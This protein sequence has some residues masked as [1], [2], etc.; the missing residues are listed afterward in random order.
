V[1]FTNL[2]DGIETQSQVWR[3]KVRIIRH[4]RQMEFEN[5][6][7]LIHEMVSNASPEPFYWVGGEKHIMQKVSGSKFVMASAETSVGVQVVD[8]FLWLAKKGFAGESLPHDCFK[9]MQYV[10]RRGNIHDFSFRGVSQAMHEQYGDVLSK[11]LTPQEVVKAKDIQA[12]FEE[13]RQKA[14]A[15]YA[16]EKATTVLQEAVE[17]AAGAVEGK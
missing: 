6:F 14:L 17:P 8:T 4:D 7:K 1:A 5:N 15:E 13:R 3:Q 11:T 12:K 16:A 10:V 2:I 9:F